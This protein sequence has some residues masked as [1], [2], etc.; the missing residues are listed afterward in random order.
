MSPFFSKVVWFRDQHAT[1]IFSEDSWWSFVCPSPGAM[2]S[3]IFL[4]LFPSKNLEVCGWLWTPDSVWQTEL[5]MCMGL[6]SPGGEM[7]EIPHIVSPFVHSFWRLAIM[8]SLWISWLAL[9]FSVF[10]LF[11][12]K[13]VLYPK[14][15]CLFGVFWSLE[16]SQASGYGGQAAGI[17]SEWWHF[18]VNFWYQWYVIFQCFYIVI[19]QVESCPI[20]VDSMDQQNCSSETVL[21]GLQL[22]FLFFL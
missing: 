14:S 9:F 17:P 21:I 22:A 10:V 8:H 19:F 7:R 1:I 11:L 15:L 12:S 6:S 20:S 2:L 5:A 16:R 13:Q 4:S 18:R 3:Y